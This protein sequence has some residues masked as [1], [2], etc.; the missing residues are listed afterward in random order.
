LDLAADEEY[1][2]LDDPF[3]DD[4]E[5]MEVFERQEEAEATV[6]KYHG[7]F[8]NHGDL[9]VSMSVVRDDSLGGKEPKKRQRKK[10]AGGEGVNDDETW[11][12]SEEVRVALGVFKDAVATWR[13]MQ[14]GEIPPMKEVRCT[15]FRGWL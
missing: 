3:I 6:T 4:S 8:V 5:L 7:F 9:E 1:Y 11:L 13:S 14:P 10:A 15:D 2:D 12:Q